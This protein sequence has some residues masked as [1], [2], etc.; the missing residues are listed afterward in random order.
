ME[1]KSSPILC[2]AVFNAAT[3]GKTQTKSELEQLLSLGDHKLDRLSPLLPVL[4]GLPVNITQN[5][6][7]KLGR[8]NG[9]TGTIVGYQFPEGTIVKSM[10]FQEC[11][12]GLASKPAK[13]IYVSV[14]QTRLK[15]RLPVVPENIPN[16]TVPILPFSC[17]KKITCLPNREF[18]VKITQIPLTPAIAATTYMLQGTT[19]EAIVSCAVNEHGRQN[20]S[21]YVV[22][23][24][25]TTF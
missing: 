18:R 6:A 1:R 11:P 24:R 16:N 20:T 21:L 5:T 8:A 2:P 9:S 3:R 7:P 19:C 14:D 12:M 4:P 23:P 17:T 10:S 25:V 22:A 13:I 15:H